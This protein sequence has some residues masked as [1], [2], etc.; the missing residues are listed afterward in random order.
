MKKEKIIADTQEYEYC[1]IC[2]GPCELNLEELNSE[3]ID[4]EKLRRE[5]LKGYW[6][7]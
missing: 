2:D 3:P 5:L 1:K 7:K 6:L 4:F